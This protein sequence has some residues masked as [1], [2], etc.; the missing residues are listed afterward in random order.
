MRSPTFGK[1]D[2]LPEVFG[3]KFALELFER[4]NFSRQFEL[5]VKDKADEGKIYG[6]IYLSIGTEYNSAAIS[7]VVKSPQIFGQHRGHSLYL[8]FGGR[9]EALRDELLGLDSGCSFGVGGSC[10]IQSK[11]INMFGHSGLLGEQ[12]PLSVGACFAK[13]QLTL[14]I[15][16]DAAIEEDYVAP[17]LGWAVTQN[18]PIIFICED[19]DLSV[20]TKTDDRRSWKAVDLANSLNMYAVDIADDPW[21]IAYHV[22]EIIKNGKPGFINI[23]TV[24]GIWHAGTGV[25]NELEW[26]R[27]ELVEKELIAMGLSNQM[28]KIN[29]TN[30]EKVGLIWQKLPQKS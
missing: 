25:D 8:S 17:A 6:P 21:L 14:T 9:P 27:Y 16:G 7:L 23:R 10:C 5:A 4:G 22:K 15:F 12:V 28:A 19:N 1:I 24:R 20:L 30:K 18:L 29:Q 13:K 26:N 2:N 11:D 3:K